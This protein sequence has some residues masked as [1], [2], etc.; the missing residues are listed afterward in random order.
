MLVS[1]VIAILS[2]TVGI[3]A[4][5]MRYTRRALEIRYRFF[6]CVSFVVLARMNFYLE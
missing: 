1:S 5:V 4:T 6:D 3:I 2:T